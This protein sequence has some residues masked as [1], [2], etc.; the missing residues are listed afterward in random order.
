MF[1]GSFSAHVHRYTSAL[2]LFL[3]CATAPKLP[4]ANVAFP[5]RHR[6]AA[7]GGSPNPGPRTLDTNG[8]TPYYVPHVIRI[9][10]EAP[11]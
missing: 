9:T 7:S 8:E 1:Q 3:P 5:P 2:I 11:P 10:K 4:R 6:V